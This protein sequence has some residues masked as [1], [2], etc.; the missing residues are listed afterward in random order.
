MVERLG[1][2]LASLVSQKP[3]RGSE[4][5]SNRSGTPASSLS[6]ED[7]VFSVDQDF[8]YLKPDTYL[9]VDEEW[10]EVDGNSSTEDLSKSYTE[11]S[12]LLEAPKSEEF[13]LDAL[14]RPRKVMGLKVSC[15]C[16]PGKET[17]G[18]R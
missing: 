10:D 7:S 12:S 1:K 9:G 13:D 4:T 8:V 15:D 5:V 6:R 14:P 18:P 2:L 11:G 3:L 16:P 17:C